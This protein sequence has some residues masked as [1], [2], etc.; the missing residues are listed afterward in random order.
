MPE[1][2]KAAVMVKPGEIQ[3]TE[4]PY[5][6]V[7]PSAA[8][9]RMEMSGICGTDKHMFKGETEHPGGHETTFPI[10]PGHENVGI[11]EELG[12]ASKLEVED[13][14]LQVGDRVVPICDVTCGQCYICRSSYG[15]TTSC[16]RDVGYGTT[17]SC[18]NPPHLFGGWAEYMYI[19]PQALLAKVPDGVPPEAAVITEVLSVPFCGFDKAMSPYPLGK[20]GFGP[21]D[22]VVILGAGPLGVCHGIM[23]KMIGAEKIII[24]GAPE[25]RLEL[26]RKI[27]ADHTV[28][29]NEI[30]DPERRLREIMALT[31]NR[32]AD[33]VAECAGV[34][35]A[36][37]QGLDMLRVGGTLLVAGNYI[38]M[39]S[40]P[41][42]PQRQI[43]SKNARI[44]GVSGQTA[45]SYAGSL[46]LIRRF[47]QTL[48]I[49]K[50]VTHRFR[51]E[52]AERALLTAISM[53]G[54]EVVVTPR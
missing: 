41:V 22:T 48:P 6:K 44:I 36:V 28:N 37:T 9:V 53:E 47:M 32:G 39:G 2:V 1:R 17:L 31:D 49:E 10:I 13:R 50:L 25:S 15:F 19:L 52:E 5:P 33:L 54:M 4:F 21:G 40:T 29:I 12:S 26:A 23:A 38:D 35:E 45:S 3:L 11:I 8:L 43:L 14:K 7:P 42:N 20:E 51:I 34:P 30:S 24:V 27:C 16:L 18:K 46:R